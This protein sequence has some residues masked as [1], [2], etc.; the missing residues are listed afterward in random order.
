MG[1][2]LQLFAGHFQLAFVTVLAV[3][4]LAGIL[5]CVANSRSQRLWRRGFTVLWLGC[6]FSWLPLNS[7]P[8]WNCKYV[9][10]VGGRFA[11]HGK[12]RKHSDPY[13]LQLVIPFE[14][15]PYAEQRLRDLEGANERDR[16]HLY[17]GQLPL[18]LLLGVVLS[19]RQW[20]AR[21]PWFFSLP[22]DCSSP[23]SLPLAGACARV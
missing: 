16:A 15:Y 19:P 18:L 17:F 8:P 12:L 1:T 3:V 5:P 4:I 6:G 9:A 11:A 20:R 7:F 2:G 14:I 22:S 21:W 10:S 13:F 23:F